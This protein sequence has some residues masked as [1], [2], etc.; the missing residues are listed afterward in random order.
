MVSYSRLKKYKIIEKPKEH[1]SY[2]AQFLPL[3]TESYFVT[4]KF[5]R[6]ENCFTFYELDIYSNGLFKLIQHRNNHLYDVHR[7]NCFFQGFYLKQK[8]FIVIKYLYK[9]FCGL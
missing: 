5:I 2:M 9:R 1:C 3:S 8:Y 7:V 6:D 4:I